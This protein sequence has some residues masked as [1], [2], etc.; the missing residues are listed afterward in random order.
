MVEFKELIKDKKKYC[1]LLKY[2]VTRWLS[3]SKCVD[4]ILDCLNFITDFVKNKVELDYGKIDL[5]METVKKIDPKAAHLIELF[6]A[7]LKLF[8]DLM[9]ATG[10]SQG[11]INVMVLYVTNEKNGEIPSYNYFEKIAN[12]W[13]RAKVKT[14]KDALD[15]INKK[16]EEKK[17]TKYSKKA[18]VKE[19]PD[20][21][22]D[23]E[24][25]ISEASNKNVSEDEKSKALE[26]AIASGLFSSHK[27]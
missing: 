13:K 6:E 3:R 25:T 12:T 23:Y 22:K 4:R 18:K 2:C 24:K 1:Y 21:Y 16:P 20:W 17:T 11:V 9:K 26:E 19:V 5:D 27:E 15:V 8:D 7:E 14:A 10:F